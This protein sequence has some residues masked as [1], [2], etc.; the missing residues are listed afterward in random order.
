MN[1]INQ[2]NRT[3]RLAA[4]R[5]RRK[6]AHKG[7]GIDYE[8]AWDNYA[9]MWRYREPNLAHIGDEWTGEGAGAAKS[10]K[11]YEDLIE[12]EYITPY[13]EAA[14][15]VMEIGVG[16]GRTA[17][18]L[19]RHC[20]SLAC[21]DISEE[22]LKAAH[23]RLGDDGVSYVKVDGMHLSGIRSHS[24]DVCFCFDTMVHLEPRDIFNYLTQIP[25]LMHGKRLCVF[26]H[27]NT[28]SDLG[29]QRFLYEW[30]DNLMGRAGGS[31]S[32][33]TNELMERFL[34]YLGYEILRQDAESVP[35]DCVWIARA[36]EKVSV[37]LKVTF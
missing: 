27:T 24:T 25:D 10:L 11:E 3:L 5:L 31:F 13:I 32:I 37:P 17:M 18:L 9:E 15:D 14:D 4:D 22:M 19:K 34:T 30:D 7:Q 33:M 8:G 35:R 23:E 2:A 20:H 36:P 26:H 6:Q 29:W 21:I 12:T 16:G 28:L 1:V